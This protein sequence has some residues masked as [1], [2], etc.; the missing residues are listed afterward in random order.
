MTAPATALGGFPVAMLWPHEVKGPAVTRAVNCLVRAGIATI[1]DLLQCTP[2]DLA[3]IRNLGGGCITEIRSA[4]AA[5]GMRLPGDE[6]ET[7]PGALAGDLAERIRREF[8]AASP[9]QASLAARLGDDPAAA[10]MV[11]LRPVWA[12]YCLTCRA[13]ITTAW[14]RSEADAARHSHAEAEADAATWR[15]A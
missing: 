6:P 4:L 11:V 15:T 14:N 9:Q 12:A 2:A 8:A 13:V 3:G 5:H 1:G 7:P 10:H